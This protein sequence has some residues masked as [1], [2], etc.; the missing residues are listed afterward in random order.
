MKI[1]LPTRIRTGL[2][3]LA[4]P[5]RVV[6]DSSQPWVAALPRQYDSVKRGIDLALALVLL[7]FA[8][9]VIAAGWVIVRATSPGAGFYTQTRVGRGGRH[10]RIIKLRTMAF[11]C[12]CTHGG[13]KWSTPGD[14]R[15]TAVGRVLR[16]THLDELPQ[17]FNVVLG[18]MSLVGPRPERP[19]FVGPLSI[20]IPE[21]TTRLAVR[22]GVTGLAQ[23]QLPADTDIESV[24]SKIVLDREYIKTR[25]LWVDARLLAGTVFYL[26][27]FSYARVKRVF[28]LPNPL[29]DDCPAMTTTERL[30]TESRA[31]SRNRHEFQDSVPAFLERA[32]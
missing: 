6:E 28:A 17:L 10:F 23:I 29:M 1:K 2:V 20:S 22:P 5:H 4:T 12:E 7:V 14:S 8:L 31:T 3:S 9:P 11:N 26:A 19:E 15:I 27:G 13:A 18:D 24:R 25:C 21:Y 30:D 32:V 16:K